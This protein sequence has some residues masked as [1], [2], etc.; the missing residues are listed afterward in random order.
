[1]AAIS[2]R[3]IL[4]AFCL[5]LLCNACK[6]DPVIPESVLGLKPIYVQSDQIIITNSEPKPFGNLGKIVLVN[7]YIY[8]NEK[9]EGIHVIDNTDPFMPITITFWSIPGNIDFTIEG[10]ILFA[11]NGRD[12]YV[13]DISDKENISLKSTVL[14]AYSLPRSEKFYPPDHIGS[15]ECVDTSLGL[16]VGWESGIILDPKCWRE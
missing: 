14:N 13:I 4:L 10:D 5:L 16:V 8:V 11:D 12:I 1:M 9:L 7:P 6:P 15:F 2:T 3:H